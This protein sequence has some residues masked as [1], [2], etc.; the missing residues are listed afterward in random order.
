MNEPYVDMIQLSLDD[1]LSLEYEYSWMKKNPAL[2][3]AEFALQQ[4]I[5]SWMPKPKGWPAIGQRVKLLPPHPF[6]G[7]TGTIVALDGM[8]TVA[9]GGAA[10]IVDLG[11]DGRRLIIYPQ[12]WEEA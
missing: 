1:A 10:P 7:Q 5:A 11:K 3:K 9:N 6:A 8:N 12:E 4:E 2:K